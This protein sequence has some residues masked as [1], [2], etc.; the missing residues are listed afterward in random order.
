M[1]RSYLL[2]FPSIVIFSVG[3]G[4]GNWAE[5]AALEA[6]T[7]WPGELDE[8]VED[9]STFGAEGTVGTSVRAVD[10]ATPLEDR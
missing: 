3:S 2:R 10:L 8:R 4:L 5:L 9:V 6:A 7:D 1:V